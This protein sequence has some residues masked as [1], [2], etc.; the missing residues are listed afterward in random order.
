MNAL[1]P[2]I[3]SDCVPATRDFYVGLLG[4]RVDFDSDW[5]VYLSAPSDSALKLAIVERGHDSVPT[6]FQSA[7]AGVLIS[8]EVDDVDQTWARAAALGAPVGQA[9]RD[10][11]FGQ[12]HFMVSDPNGL[13]VDVIT[14]IPFTDDFLAEHQSAFAGPAAG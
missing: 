13:L 4:L 11:P 9:L 3:L 6:S 5:A 10:E 2:T 14:P 12:R 8:V 7:A 1:Y